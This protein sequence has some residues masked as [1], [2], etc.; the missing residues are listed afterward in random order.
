MTEAIT[1]DDLL[2][3]AQHSRLSRFEATISGGTSSRRGKAGQQIP[4]LQAS[5]NCC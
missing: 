4:C 2:G 1:Q 3:I 5:E